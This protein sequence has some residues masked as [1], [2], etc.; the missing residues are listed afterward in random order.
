MTDLQ[1]PSDPFHEL[2][3]LHLD[4]VEPE[5]CRMRLPFKP[6]L[7]TA[8]D[9]V[10]GGAIS[11]LIDTA[12]VTAAWSNADSS[13]TRGAT[14][15]LSISYLSAAHSVDLTAEARVIRR[16]HSLVFVEVDVTSAAGERIAK[17]MLTYKL[18]YS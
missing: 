1:P 7:R 4:V 6:E 9:V 16:G 14:A 12:G 11:T 5:F 10:H 8:G 15:G 18:G 2:L 13:A 3:G 17:G